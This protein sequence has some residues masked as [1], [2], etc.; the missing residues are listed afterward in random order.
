VAATVGESEAS[1]IFRCTIQ[2]E[3]G[4]GGK[5]MGSWELALVVVK[6][7]VAH[8]RDKSYFICC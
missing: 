2:S 1:M 5:E 6:W 7:L 3:G 8:I 4:R